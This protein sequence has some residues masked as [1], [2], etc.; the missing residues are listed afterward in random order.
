[1]GAKNLKAVAVRGRGAIPVA[2]ATPFQ[3]VRGAANRALREDNMTKVLRD[4]GSAG[5][6]DYF[7]YLGEMPKKYFQRGEFEGAARVTGASLTESLLTGVSTC[8]G[9]VIAC[10]RVVRLDGGGERK[11]PEYETMIGFGPNL[12]ID[13][14][15]FTAR[16]GELCDRYGM[17]TISL[18]N[19]LGLAFT[20]F[21]QGLILPAD[22]G[23]LKLRWGDK[24][25]VEQL[26]HLTAVRSG[27]GALLAQGALTLGRHFGAEEFAMQVNGLEMAYHDPRG[28]SG[29]ALVYATSPR[30][31]C[32][33]QSDYFLVDIGHVEDR[34]GMVYLPRQAGAEKA[35]NVGLHQDWRTLCNALVLCFFAN[36]S[37]LT[38]LELVNAACGLDLSL[39]E[40][41]R[42]GER[43]WNLKRAINIRFGLSG[44]HDILPAQ[45][46]RPFPDGG[47]A[48][49]VPDLPAMLSA[50]YRVRGWDAGTG[51]PS[52]RRLVDLG[53]ESIADELWPET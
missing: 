1:M 42:S 31:A 44:K 33:N 13:D 3:T 34:L 24:Q 15:A 19:T 48:G 26:I 27:F 11:G 40:L 53:L 14:L 25:V 30:G 50:Y 23:G 41:L 47:S 7:D 46:S 35:H 37:P 16:M 45:M 10:G 6:S 8:H 4:T 5:G 12:L 43:A 52:R 28:A 38:T 20:L 39:E 2:R 29:M 21:E 9:C 22:T 51:K 49:Y 32:H 17:D 36:V 18:S